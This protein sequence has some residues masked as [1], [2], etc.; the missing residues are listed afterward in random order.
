[1]QQISSFSTFARE[2]KDT[3][4]ITC[5]LKFCTKQRLIAQIREK[6]RKPLI[7]LFMLTL[8]L[9]RNPLYTSPTRTWP[10]F[11]LLGTH[12]RYLGSE[13]SSVYLQSAEQAGLKQ[14]CT[15]A[16]KRWAGNQSLSAMLKP[17]NPVGFKG[18]IVF[19]LAN[20]ICE[21][22]WL[23]ACRPRVEPFDY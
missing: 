15:V 12:V 18:F 11:T 23:L 9:I 3:E 6:I 5:I 8:S 1:M 10:D 7:V 13:V 20:A 22:L 21:A 2:S 19:I 16:D 17:L 4:H 14:I